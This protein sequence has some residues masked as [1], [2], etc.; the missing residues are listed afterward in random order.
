[1]AGLADGGGGYIS[2]S[3]PRLSIH[4]QFVEFDENA[5]I[6]FDIHLIFSY[7]KVNINSR[8]K[9]QAEPSIGLPVCFFGQPLRP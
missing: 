2:F 4:A 8:P 6:F 9:C 1:M 5:D 7:V 3:A